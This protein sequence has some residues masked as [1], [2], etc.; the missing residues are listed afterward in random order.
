MI[1]KSQ[2]KQK[3]TQLFAGLYQ[4]AKDRRNRQY[5]GI[6]KFVEIKESFRKAIGS[7]SKLIRTYRKQKLSQ[8]D[9]KYVEA[10]SQLEWNTRVFDQRTRLTE[11]ICEEPVFNTQ[12]LGYQSREILSF[13]K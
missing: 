11:Y 13:I 5:L 12:R 1:K 9:P 10:T 4:K 6:I 3:L 8:K 7:S 2:Q